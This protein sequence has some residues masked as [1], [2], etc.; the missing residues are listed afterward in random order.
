MIKRF[1]LAGALAL[2]MILGST[3]LPPVEAQRGHT[4]AAPKYATDDLPTCSA[5]INAGRLAWDTTTTSLKICDGSSWVESGTFGDTSL[6][7]GTANTVAKFNSGATDLADS[8]LTDDGTAVSLALDGTGAV[9]GEHRL[10]I[11]TQRGLP[12]L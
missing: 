4:V 9:R 5:A 3:T 12:R 11:A 2:G 8:L 10:G 6:T 7:V 1:L